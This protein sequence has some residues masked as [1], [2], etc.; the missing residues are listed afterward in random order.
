MNLNVFRRLRK[1]FTLIELL[2]VVAIIAILAAM[3]LPALSAARE[4]ARRSSCLNNLRQMGTAFQAYSGDYGGY[5]PSWVGMGAD[6]WFP[7][8]DWA[9][10]YRQCSHRT[11]GTCDWYDWGV[12]HRNSGTGHPQ[13]TPETLISAAFTGRPGLDTPVNVHGWSMAFHRVIAR[14]SIGGGQW[15]FNEEGTLKHGPNGMGFLLS[16]GYI[17]DAR[18]YYCPS[19]AGMPR[20]GAR[21]VVWPH[22]EAG[23]DNL[24]DWQNAGGFDAETMLYGRWG[25]KG[26]RDTTASTL[27]SHYSY[28]LTPLMARTPW[29]A[30]M[31][32]QRTGQPRSL[33]YGFTR[34]AAHARFGVPQ[35]RTQ[36]ELG[37][38]AFVS[39]TF[40]K[41]GYFAQYAD[42]YGNRYQ[43]PMTIEDTM[44]Y[45][46]W[47]VHAHRTA[48]NVLYGDGSV[49]QYSDP[50]ERIVWHGQADGN[51]PAP[52]SNT[53]NPYNLLGTTLVNSRPFPSRV[54]FRLAQDSNLWR[55]S[56]YKIWNDFDNE[57]GLDVFDGDFDVS[58]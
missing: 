49:R 39:D 2:V 28:R 3:L 14:G 11:E 5:L 54:N 55:Y 37:S 25:D 58:P 33:V 47:P 29:C 12:Q 35:F 22:P 32:G 27:W 45:P 34:P 46:G 40:T 26:V 31:E 18:L 1:A 7:G 50:Q 51:N 10:S 9:D 53:M 42:A 30:S 23:G 16:G 52:Q 8:E 17:G 44:R 21:N 56:S 19:A 48:F 43:W 38:R 24:G 4:K 36:R 15:R 6:H 13:R 20:D 57:V 41:G